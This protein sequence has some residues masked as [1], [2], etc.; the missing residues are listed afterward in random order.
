[1]LIEEGALYDVLLDEEAELCDVEARR[2]AVAR[3]AELEEKK[4]A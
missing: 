1:M 2:D 3:A 4:R